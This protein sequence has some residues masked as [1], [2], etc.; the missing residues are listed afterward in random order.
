MRLWELIKKN[1]KYKIKW[2][3]KFKTKINKKK[4]VEC[5]LTHLLPSACQILMVLSFEA[6][7]KKFPSSNQ[8][9]KLIAPSWLLPGWSMTLISSP[10]TPS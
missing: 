1:T 2:L 10:V 8:S 6:V 3:C 9:Q 5:Y 7:T 4:W